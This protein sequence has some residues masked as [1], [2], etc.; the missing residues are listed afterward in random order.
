MSSFPGRMKEY[1]TISIDR[2]DRENL[3]ARAYFLSHCHKDHMK[4]LKG[5]LLKRKLKFS[6]TVKLYCSFVT[7][8][9]LLNNPKYDFWEDRIVA[10]EL[11]SPT[12]VS[13]TDE[14][15]GEV[16]DV[17]VTLLPAGHCPGSVMFLF[18]GAQGTVLYTGDFRLAAGDVA[19][20]EHLHSG[21]RV[22]DIQTVYLD[23]TFYDPRFYQIP[24]R[25]ACLTGVRKLVQ[26]WICRSPYHVVWLN[27]KAA[28]GYEYLFTNLGQEFNS[29]V[30]VNSLKMF[31][32]M[33]EILEHVTTNRATQIHAC[34]HPK[35]DELFRTNRLPCGSL[36]SDGTPLRII[37]I[38]PS[39]MWFGERTRKTNVIVKMGESS[40]RAC[41]SFHSSYS[42]IK[43]FLSYISPVHIYPNVVP[44]GR[45][46][47]DVSELLNLMRRKHAD[48]D[49]IVY[50]PLGKLK[51]ARI[52]SMSHGSDTDDELFEDVAVAP[53]RKKLAVNLEKEHHSVEKSDL[54]LTET[55]ILPQLQTSIQTSNYMDCTESNDDD[56]DDDVEKVELPADATPTPSCKVMSPPTPKPAPPTWSSFFMAEPVVTD[57]SCELENSQNSQA[58]STDQM[59][60]QSPELFSDNDESESG[61]VTSSQSTYVSEAALESLSQLDT[62]P[63]QCNTAHTGKAFHLS[64]LTDC[65]QNQN[66]IAGHKDPVSDS[67]VSSDF[68]LP[69]TPGSKA[70]QPGELKELYKTLGAGEDVNTNHHQ[71]SV[72]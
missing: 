20:M 69:M 66:D 49:Q 26:D 61:H 58:P 1:P 53:M 9:L 57:D 59:T 56:D 67:Q 3:H 36:A 62:E 45:T 29:Q 39:T 7:K 4:G 68:D 40:Y 13:L 70:P 12:H 38:K 34:R 44:P 10:L 43:D 72:V 2:F 21:N 31:R 51:R 6:L 41:F 8:E 54:E 27:C 18:E 23:S 16:E 35:D 37:S 63:V 64:D 48:G 24:S 30:H 47:E 15:T 32:Q 42:E 14:V 17:V 71:Q 19:R 52:K 25:E 50:K 46:V 28:Y 60:P 11:D 33:P 5:P 55:Q 65:E 22:K